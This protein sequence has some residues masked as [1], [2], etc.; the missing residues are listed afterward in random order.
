MTAPR[1]LPCS[2]WRPG[3]HPWR[4]GTRVPRR[5]PLSTN[6]DTRQW[7]PRLRHVNNAQDV[8]IIPSMLSTRRWLYTAP[9]YPDA[10]QWSEDGRL[11]AAAGTVALVVDPYRLETSLHFVETCGFDATSVSRTNASPKDVQN[12]IGFAME[13]LTEFAMHDTAWKATVRQVTCSPRGAWPGMN[14]SLLALVQSDHKVQDPFASTDRR[15]I[16]LFSC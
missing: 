1:V 4:T 12:S 16:T 9:L 15:I 5:L 10:L 3:R 11:A 13:T 6:I 7:L 8:A 14:R 2:V